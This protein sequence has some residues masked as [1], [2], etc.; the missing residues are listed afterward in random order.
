MN[1]ITKVLIACVLLFTLLSRSSAQISTNTITY[2][3][4]YT[5]QNSVLTL[6]ISNAIVSSNDVDVISFGGAPSV[7]LLNGTYTNFFTT[8]SNTTGILGYQVATNMNGSGYQI[9][10]PLTTG[11]SG[12]PYTIVNASASTIYYVSYDAINWYS[13][14]PIFVPAPTGAVYSTLTNWVNYS[15]VL[16]N[17][18]SQ[19]SP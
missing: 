11:S 5:W 17:L 10:G 6:T 3:G 13:A 7:Y 15:V 16:S 9:I 14:S 18:I 19:T 2:Y 8:I 4:S 1:T 12:S